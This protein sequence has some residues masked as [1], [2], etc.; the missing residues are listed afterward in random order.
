MDGGDELAREASDEELSAGEDAPL[1]GGMDGG[2]PAEADTERGGIAGQDCAQDDGGDGDGIV[3][4]QGQR[5]S[6]SEIQ[7]VQNL[8][9]RCLQVRH[10]VLAAA[11]CTHA[12]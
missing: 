3:G 4:A 11:A 8:V 10:C 7:L 12:R 2:W 5:I 1:V 6:A 9:E